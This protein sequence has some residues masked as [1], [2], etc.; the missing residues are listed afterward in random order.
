M[1]DVLLKSRATAI[2]G[3]RI[4]TIQVPIF[5]TAKGEQ[6]MQPSTYLPMGR[7]SWMVMV[8]LPRRIM[9]AGRPWR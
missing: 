6:R 2:E 8:S 9:V 1:V 5:S 4:G 7:S 3:R